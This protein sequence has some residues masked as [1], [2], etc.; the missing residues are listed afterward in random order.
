MSRKLKS[1]DFTQPSS[2]TMAD[3][4][5]YPWDEWFDGDIWELTAGED[6][7]GHPLMMERIIRTRATGKHARVSLRHI[8]MNGEPWGK[9]VLQR[10]D[11]Q[12]PEQVKR[13]STAQKRAATRAANKNGNGSKAPAKAVT[14]L[15]PAKK[16]AKANG[17]RIVSKRPAK[18]ATV[19]AAL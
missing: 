3:K 5:V 17:E 6:F 14:K 13:Q 18:K 2:L 16:V 9:I 10:T 15:A 12:G 19:G 8:P 1:Y 4:A 11:V 7:Q